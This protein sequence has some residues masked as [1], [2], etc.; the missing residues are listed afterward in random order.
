MVKNISSS[1]KFCFLLLLALFPLLEITGETLNPELPTRD[2]TAPPNVYKTLSE[3]SIEPNNLNV[4]A[5]FTD[6][7]K[8]NSKVMI[9]NAILKIGD[10]IA[11]LTIVATE[12]DKII[13]Q[14]E[15]GREIFVPINGN[16]IKYQTESTGEK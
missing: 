9:G 12:E 4:R 1:T 11:G 3:F 13:L 5:I 14:N 16:Q 6:S 2:P 10:K 15:Q 7:T 8:S